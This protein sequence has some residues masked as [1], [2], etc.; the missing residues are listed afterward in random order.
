MSFQP[1]GR[2]LRHYRREA[3]KTLLD[4]ATETGLS[5][6]FLSQAERDLT[7]ISISSLTSIA[8]AL[9]VP[10]RALLEQPQQAEPDSHH[11]RREVYATR[12]AGQTYE[13]LSTTFPGQVIN[14]VKMTLPVG[15]ASEQISHDGDEFVFVLAGSVRYSVGGKDYDLGPHDSL[16]F[17]AHQMHAVS[18]TG[19]TPA[20]LLSIGTLPIFDDERTR[21]TS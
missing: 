19:D 3:G 7:G 2:R 5:I 18:N 20:E 12:A 11:G 16:H 6:G 1:I 21:G 8:R 9:N 14:A 10:L 13:R 15:H 17:D 4:V